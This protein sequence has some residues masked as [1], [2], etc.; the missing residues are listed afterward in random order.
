MTESYNEIV[1]S[2]PSYFKDYVA[3]QKY[4]LYT[5]R[6]HAVWRYIMKQN[7]SFLGEY[8]HPSYLE[9][10]SGTGISHDKIPNIDEMNKSLK[11]IGWKAIIVEGFIPPAVFMDFQAH[12]ILPISADIRS[13][14][15]L[16]Y[17][18]APD[19][20]HESAGHAPI[21]INEDY[22][23][24]VQKIGEYGAKAI[25]SKQDRD[26]YEAIR[27]LSIIK[28]YP[29][30]KPEE[31]K[32]AEDDLTLKISRQRYL[33]EASMISRLHWWTVEY[34][35][36]GTP[37]KYTQ[38]GAGL[39]SSVGESKSCLAPDVKKI[40]LS[41]DCVYMGYDITNRQPQLYVARNF[42]HLNR[43]LEEFA[44]TL[45]FRKGGTESLHKAIGSDQVATAVLSSGIQI[46]GVFTKVRTDEEANAY[47]VNTTGETALAY[48]NDELLGHGV[49]YHSAGFGSPIGKLKK[50]EK[51]LE[52]LDQTDLKNLGLIIGQTAKLEFRS[53]VTVEG[54][55]DKVTQKEGKN[56]LFTFSNCFVLDN[57]GE[58]LFDPAWGLYDMAIGESVTS[59]FAGSADK[60][61]YN[62]YQ[63]KSPHKP[64]QVQYT[65]EEKKVHQ[66]YGKISHLKA[67]SDVGPADIDS[68][69]SEIKAIAPNEWLLYQE[70]LDLINHRQLTNE[71]PSLREELTTKISTLKA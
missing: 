30:A 45:S 54:V 29:H 38:Y 12:R 61:H 67:T 31:I 10:L 11:D 19:I 57:D 3:D 18:P 42:A 59:V 43:V 6:D 26:V 60:V 58:I 46:S 70:T 47:Y 21:L 33:S 49:D 48:A 13:L 56:I 44:D 65:N 63:Q 66:L 17:T 23:H 53:G 20:V 24:F 15:H 7:K 41:T 5:E 39:L 32:A 69:I 22:G 52:L 4:D 35:L 71:R 1:N 25:S 50:T 8:A 9:G 34:G 28:E 55:L 37:E 36:I 40:P 62:V 64:I 68:I 14:E 27:Y 16:D 51:P 2:L